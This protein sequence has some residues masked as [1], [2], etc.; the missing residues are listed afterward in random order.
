MNEGVPFNNKIM[1]KYDRVDENNTKQNIIIK[2][3]KERGRENL[4]SA[5]F[6]GVK[7]FHFLDAFT[8]Y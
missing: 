3:K 7:M 8:T 5:F 1:L 4:I 2:K 6:T